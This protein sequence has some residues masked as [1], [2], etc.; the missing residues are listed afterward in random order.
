MSDIIRGLIGLITLIGIG[1]ACSN[2]R[3]NINW[4]LVGTGVSLQLLI[5][6]ALKIEIVRLLFEGLSAFFIRLMQFTNDGS[7][8]LFGSLVTDMSSFG[9]I[10]A[11]QVLPTIVFISALSSALYYLNVLQK[12]VYLFAWV[13]NK[14]MRLS[15][16]ES[17][18]A[19]ANIFVGQ[20]EAPL[21]VKPYVSKMTKSEIMCLM[22]GGMATVAGGVFIAYISMLGGTDPEAQKLFGKHLLMASIISAPAAIV[23]AKLMIPETEPI[24]QT[25]FIPKNQIGSNVLDAIADGTAQGIKL[26]VNVAGM[27]LV[28][29]ALVALINF[30]L[31]DLIGHY[32]QLN[33]VIANATNER[34][35]GLSLE[36]ILGALGA[37]VAW[38][39]GV[40]NADLMSVGQLLGTKTV[41]NEFVAYENLA[42]MKTDGQ[43]TDMK[44]ILIATYALCG[45]ANFSSIGI[46][47]GGIS[48]LAPDQR[49]LLARLGFRA[50]ISGTMA[51]L[52]TA[53]VAGMLF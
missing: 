3:K 49:A 39:I 6:L 31:Q 46:Q 37:P 19:A 20:T 2:N 18:A 51:C 24:D 13:M 40:P 5:G 8:F 50:L 32:T 34:Y 25:L 38:I 7:R 52:M 12:V 42:A 14:T 43:L 11:F 21:M 44:S 28:F 4:R 9:Y 45:F 23:A 53:C 22:S 27:L 16:A 15:G 26:A 35:S 29:I 33:K 36:F 47:I 41:L 17:L 30:V 1:Y 10:F 48:V